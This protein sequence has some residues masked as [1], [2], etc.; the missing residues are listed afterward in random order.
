MN[1][2]KAEEPLKTTSF[3]LPPLLNKRLE[4]AAEAEFGGDKSKFVRQAIREYLDL[5]EEVN[6]VKAA[7]RSR[8]VAEEVEKGKA[9]TRKAT[10]PLPKIVGSPNP[11]TSAQSR[12][13]Q[14]EQQK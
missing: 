11:G 2:Q 3:K 1:T 14:S 5:L 13:P 8:R 10:G 6:V 4:A 12:S 7:R 9:G